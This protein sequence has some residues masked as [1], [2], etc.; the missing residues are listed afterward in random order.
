M[1]Y[2]KGSDRAKVTMMVI[3]VM[4][5][6]GLKVTIETTTLIVAKVMVMN[7]H[8]SLDSFHLFQKVKSV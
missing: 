5:V 8:D 2:S 4:V 1:L 7:T 6:K 3:A